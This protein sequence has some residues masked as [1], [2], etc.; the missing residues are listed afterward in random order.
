M[1]SY[2]KTKEWRKHVMNT[3]EVTEYAKQL[4]VE[5]GLKKGF[6]EGAV[7]GASNLV[8]TLREFGG[9]NQQILQQLKQKYGEIFSEKELESFLKQG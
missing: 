4:G 2:R 9:T 3:E 5:E 1:D 8:S 6:K 7:N